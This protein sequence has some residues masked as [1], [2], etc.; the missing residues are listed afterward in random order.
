M[1]NKQNTESIDRCLILFSGMHGSGKTLLAKKISAYYKVCLLEKD[2]IQSS[3]LKL[4]LVKTSTKD[5]Y[6]LMFD[7]ANLQMSHGISLI[8]DGIFP[9]VEYRERAILLAK[10]HKFKFIA[11]FVYCSDISEWKCRYEM[12]SNYLPMP[13]WETVQ[14]L[15]KNFCPWD[16][17]VVLKVDSVESPEKNLKIITE[18]IKYAE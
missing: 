5:G 13:K 9:K 16:D 15:H 7:L 12:R 8:L 4:S 14:E 10:K 11:I 18:F 6:E 3:L 2:L 1:L 17:K